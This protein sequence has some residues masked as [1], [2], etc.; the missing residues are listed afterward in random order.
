M[1]NDQRDRQGACVWLT[2]LSGAGKSTTA[3]TLRALLLEHGRQVTL[4]DGDIVRTH[5]SKGLGFSKE[6]RD[7]NVRR[8]GFVAAEIVR[9]GGIVICAVISP[10]RATRGDVRKMIEPGHFVEVFVD[11]PIEICEQR[12]VKG[13][14]AK[15]RRGEIKEFT[16]VSD[17]YESPIDPEIAIDA[18]NRTPQENARMIMELLQQRGFVRQAAADETRLRTSSR[19]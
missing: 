12:D 14:Y 13:M 4:L 10:Y 5:L 3:E 6:D 7:T 15:A 19:R 11:T 1:S 16:G 18:V 17:P 2:G 9:H 8:I